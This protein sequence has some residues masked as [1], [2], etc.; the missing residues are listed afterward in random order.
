MDLKLLIILTLITLITAQLNENDR[1]II[2]NTLSTL[3][4]ET[5][6]TFNKNLVDTYKA[7]FALT[8]IKVPIPNFP[9]I[10]KELSFETEHGNVLSEY[11]QLN[12]VLNCKLTF[13]N[14]KII[15]N[16]YTSLKHLQE[17]LTVNYLVGNKIDYDAINNLIKGFLTEDNHLTIT[18][19]DTNYSLKSTGLGLDILSK[20]YSKASNST[21]SELTDIFSKVYDNIV[22]E[23]QLMSEV[24]C[25]NI[26][27]WFIC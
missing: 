23:L 11:V 20:I 6:G 2:K 5:S 18:K 14:A 25:T 13:T 22:D 1:T 12:K 19:G 26:E 17:D 24:I 3:Q 9:R 10:C 7:V 16:E 21:K 27:C 8:S 4:D 15:E